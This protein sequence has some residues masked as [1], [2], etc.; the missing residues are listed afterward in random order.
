MAGAQGSA[1]DHLGR[2][3]CRRDQERLCQHMP[4]L[5]DVS[6]EIEL[7]G[8]NAL[9]R[10]SVGDRQCPGR[11]LAQYFAFKRESGHRAVIEYTE[12]VDLQFNAALEHAVP[13][14]TYWGDS[15]ETG[16][17]QSGQIA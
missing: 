17:M 16:G 12:K 8:A 3:V 5:I 7:G 6:A 13:D 2:V 11:G 4:Q 9:G 15:G 1:F 10:R 14:T